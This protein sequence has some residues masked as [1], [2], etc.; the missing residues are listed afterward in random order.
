MRWAAFHKHFSRIS[1]LPHRQ[2]CGKDSN[3][4][5]RP[6]FHHQNVF[7]VRVSSCACEF[8][9]KSGNNEIATRCAA[10]RETLRGKRKKWK[11]NW[12]LHHGGGRNKTKQNKSL[13]LQAKCSGRWNMADRCGGDGNKGW[14]KAGAEAGR[15]REWN[16]SGQW[17]SDGSEVVLI[18]ES[19]GAP[20]SAATSK[21]FEKCQQRIY[22]MALMPQ[23]SRRCRFMLAMTFLMTPIEAEMLSKC[24]WNCKIR[25]KPTVNSCDDDTN[26]LIKKGIDEHTRGKLKSK[27]MKGKAENM[28]TFPKWKLNQILPLRSHLYS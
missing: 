15:G 18:T 1:Q 20:D 19:E 2:S 26:V 21:C 17:Q 13:Q 4:R 23:R 16:G 25:D 12:R 14:I 3:G 10:N 8:R 6:T 11:F 5:A 28:K 27:R 24:W 22:K 7:I 9:H